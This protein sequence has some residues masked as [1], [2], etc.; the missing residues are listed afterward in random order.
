MKGQGV[1]LLDVFLVGPVF[2]WSGRKTADE[3]HTALGGLLMLLGALTVIYNG[4]NYLTRGRLY[5]RIRSETGVDPWQLQRGIEV[6][7]EHTTDPVTAR[8]IALDHLREH[9]RYYSKLIQAG[10]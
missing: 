7:M 6:E 10:L 9:P 1:R 4:A 8:K 5:D 3:G 2:F